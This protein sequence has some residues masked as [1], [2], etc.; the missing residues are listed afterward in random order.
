MGWVKTEESWGLSRGSGEV[1]EC[2]GYEREIGR[3]A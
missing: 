1:I 2:G 3:V